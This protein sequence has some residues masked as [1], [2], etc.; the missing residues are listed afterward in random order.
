MNKSAIALAVA[1]ALAASTAVQADTTLYGS[2]RVSVDYVNPDGSGPHY[3]D[4]VN[5]SSRLGVRG[6]EDLGNGLSAIYQYEFGVDT[7]DGG[8]FN[9]NRPRV[10][11]LKGDF[12]TFTLGNQWTPYYNVLGITDV[13]NSGVSYGNYLGDFRMSNTV[14]YLTPNWNGFSSEAQLQMNGAQDQSGVDQWDANI[15]Y[16]NGPFLAGVTGQRSQTSGD[17]LYG[18]ALGFSPGAWNFGVIAE[19]CAY[20]DDNSATEIRLCDDD[21]WE[22]QGLVE[23]ELGSNVLRASYAYEKHNNGGNRNFYQFGVQ[24]NLS[25]RSRLWAEY[26]EN[27]GGEDHVSVGMR[28]DF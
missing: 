10:L 21:V 8:N 11:G 24:H 27:G 26:I 1:A 28:H 23:Y 15:K 7:T 13:F 6:S 4:V 19:N 14:N 3:W 2:A 18:A 17:W 12:G 9:S 5:N 22:S 20:N 16:T 25:K